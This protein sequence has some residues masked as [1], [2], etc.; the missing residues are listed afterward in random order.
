M[1]NACETCEGSAVS[2]RA[3]EQDT[4]CTECGG[5]G[6]AQMP[7]SLEGLLGPMQRT[8]GLVAL[9]AFRKLEE[10]DELLGQGRALEGQATLQ[11][12]MAMLSSLLPGGYPETCDDGGSDD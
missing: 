4:P 7:G 12:G 11:T 10:A 8:I 1:S 9:R 3:D 6:L 2:R 5:T